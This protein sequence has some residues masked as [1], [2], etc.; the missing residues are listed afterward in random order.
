MV[1][2]G[3]LLGISLSFMIGPLFFSIVQASLQ[4]GFWAGIAVASGMW[5]SDCL[6]VGAVIFGVD[7]FA[8]IVAMPG[9]RFQAGV[10]GGSLLMVF[11]LA[12]LLK[13][14]KRGLSLLNKRRR[15]RQLS[16]L[17]IRC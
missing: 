6:Y 4:R 7:R 12:S 16:P 8:A 1:W 2:N 17:R 11:G 10:L 15:L 14:S 5:A 13:S 9:F 3:I